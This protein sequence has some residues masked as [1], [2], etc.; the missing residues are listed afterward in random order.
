MIILLTYMTCIHWIPSHIG[1]NIFGYR[2]D[3][4]SALGDK[5][6]EEAWNIAN[7]DDFKNQTAYVIFQIQTQVFSWERSVCSLQVMT[8]DPSPDGPSLLRDDF[9]DQ[10]D[11]SQKRSV[12][13][14]PWVSKNKA[15]QILNNSR[16]LVSLFSKIRFAWEYRFS[17]QSRTSCFLCRR[18]KYT[19]ARTSNFGNIQAPCWILAPFK[20]NTGS[21]DCFLQRSQTY[22]FQ[23][24]NLTRD[25]HGENR[26]VARRVN[27]QSQALRKFHASL[28]V[29]R[30]AILRKHEHRF[31]VWQFENVEQTFFFQRVICFSCFSWQK[32]NFGG[33]LR[34]YWR[35]SPPHPPPL[36]Q[37]VL[38]TMNHASPKK[39]DVVIIGFYR[40]WLLCSRVLVCCS[41]EGTVYQPWQSLEATEITCGMRAKGI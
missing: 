33:S 7:N 29:L 14:T 24:E 31:F 5:L 6:A 32:V 25:E 36:M 11:A 15:K 18:Q 30:S 16:R 2:L 27:Y 41:I 39:K 37:L 26:V 8:A 40:T 35:W 28:I 10:I 38:A 20:P 19:V 17:R 3:E 4:G 9:D 21:P 12:H 1:K 13:V 22:F 34:V 23:V